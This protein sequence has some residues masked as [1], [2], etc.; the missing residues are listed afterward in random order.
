M[1]SQIAG[2]AADNRAQVVPLLWLFTGPLLFPVSAA[3][4]A[5]LLFA[6]AAGP[7]RAIGIAAVVALA[8]VFGSAG[9]PTTRSGPQ[10]C[11]WPPV[12]SSLIAGW[13]AATPA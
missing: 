5:W 2:Y 10:P 1:A 12:A 9:R 11:A 6:R 7:W 13:P 4:L 3:G 8:L